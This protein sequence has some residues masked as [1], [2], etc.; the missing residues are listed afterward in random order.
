MKASKKALTCHLDF[1]RS[2]NYISG[3]TFYSNP[4][5]KFNNKKSCEQNEHS[6]I[7]GN[8]GKKA[9]LHEKS[10]TNNLVRKAMQKMLPKEWRV[11]K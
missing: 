11:V 9:V 5:V 10:Q 7:D 3:N 2:I 8:L 6:F 1:F 4:N